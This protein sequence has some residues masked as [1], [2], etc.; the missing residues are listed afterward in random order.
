MHN[1]HSGHARWTTIGPL[2]PVRP[3]VRLKVGLAARPAAA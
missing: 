1:D 2:R 3:G